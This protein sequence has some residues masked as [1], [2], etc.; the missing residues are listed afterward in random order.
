MCCEVC[1]GL[2][3]DEHCEARLTN[4]MHMESMKFLN[5]QNGHL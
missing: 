3:F 2:N 1:G 5:N 4:D